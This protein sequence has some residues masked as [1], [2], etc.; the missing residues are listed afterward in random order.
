[1]L[2]RFRGLKLGEPRRKLYKTAT[3]G[4]EITNH[5]GRNGNLLKEIAVRQV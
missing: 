3:W 4:H 5:R 2:N 1:M